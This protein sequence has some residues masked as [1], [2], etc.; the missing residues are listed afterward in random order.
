MSKS[1]MKIFVC[2]MVCTLFTGCARRIG[3]EHY[4]QATVGEASTTY[5]G[6]IV[7]ARPVVVGQEQLGDN[8]AGTLGGGLL[9]GLAGSQI[10]KG[11][12]QVA[13]M[14]GGA[15]LGA[16][17]GAFAEDK[18]KE[19]EGIEYVVRLNNG[20]LRTVVQGPEPRLSP[21]QRVLV[22][23]GQNARSRVI[24]D[25]SGLSEVQML[26]TPGQR[27]EVVHSARRTQY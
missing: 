23:V 22:I 18:L 16:V 5:Q 15:V 10:G 17:A 12:G 27:V 24:P 2:L 6:V 20:S 3:G 4:G 14:A 21:G 8:T 7:S 19:Q 25:N 26:E 11:R 1:T 13:A 9:G